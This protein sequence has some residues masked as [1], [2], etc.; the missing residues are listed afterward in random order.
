MRNVD[1][2]VR[3]V[4]RGGCPRG[5]NRS[6]SN[7]IAAAASTTTAA[8]SKSSSQSLG[9]KKSQVHMPSNAGVERGFNGP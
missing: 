1:S 9:K 2:S 4:G 3:R 8:P 5:G 6:W 7:G